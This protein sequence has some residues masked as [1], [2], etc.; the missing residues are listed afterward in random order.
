[1]AWTLESCSVADT[2]FGANGGFMYCTVYPGG[3]LAASGLVVV[4]VA[5]G[6]VTGVVVVVGATPGTALAGVNTNVTL[7]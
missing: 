7:S 2:S 5:P 4:V 6:S 1:M 3:R